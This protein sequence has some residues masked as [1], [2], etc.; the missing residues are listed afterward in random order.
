ML[1]IRV[2][3]V[4]QWRIQDFPIANVKHTCE[5]CRSILLGNENGYYLIM[6]LYTVLRFSL[7]MQSINNNC[8]SYRL[9]C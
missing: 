4:D 5:K 2:K 9:L 8:T 6:Y 7:K 1:N 3:N